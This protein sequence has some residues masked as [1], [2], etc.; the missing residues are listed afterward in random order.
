MC[1]IPFHAVCQTAL[2]LD[3]SSYLHHMDHLSNHYQSGKRK[4]KCKLDIKV[5]FKSPTSKILSLCMS[6]VIC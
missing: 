1:L 5:F 4:C 2:D 6:R 3:V